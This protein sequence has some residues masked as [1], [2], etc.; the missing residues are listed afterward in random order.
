M[1]ARALPPAY[2]TETG[3]KP[4]VLSGPAAAAGAT[5]DPVVADN[6]VVAEARTKAAAARMEPRT[7]AEERAF[8]I[9]IT[10]RDPAVT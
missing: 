4:L 3:K 10:S 6:P 8:L 7:F 1:G 5:A 9:D 2:Q